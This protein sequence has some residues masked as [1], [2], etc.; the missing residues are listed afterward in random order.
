MSTI[1]TVSITVNNVNRAPVA[2]NDAAKKALEA[3]RNDP[4]MAFAVSMG[5]VDNAISVLTELATHV[6]N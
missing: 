4:S 6:G 1:L 3:V 5:G 2:A